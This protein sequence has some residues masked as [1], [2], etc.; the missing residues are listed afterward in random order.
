MSAEQGDQV[1][2]HWMG[3]FYHLGFGVAKNVDKAIEN[4]LIAAKGGNG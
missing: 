2:I 3:V 4:L 1:A